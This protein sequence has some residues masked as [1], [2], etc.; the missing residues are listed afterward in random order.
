M[1]DGGLRSRV[2]K[3]V[4]EDGETIFYKRGFTMQE[5]TP[6]LPKSKAEPIVLGDALS[7]YLNNYEV[8]RELHVS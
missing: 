4:N 7:D 6:W 3:T 1:Y 5:Y 2:G 8:R